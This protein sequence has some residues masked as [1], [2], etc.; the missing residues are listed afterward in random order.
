MY[1]L[2]LILQWYNRV[3]KVLNMFLYCLFSQNT[4]IKKITDTKARAKEDN[5][6]R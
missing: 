1:Y 3:S 2:H 5:R 4:F 6:Y